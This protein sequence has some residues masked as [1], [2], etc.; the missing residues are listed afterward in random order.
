[1][2]AQ[3][4]DREAK[5]LAAAEEKAKL[6]KYHE[7]MAQEALTAR[8]RSAERAAEQKAPRKWSKMVCEVLGRAGAG[9]L[10]TNNAS[11]LLYSHWRP[12]ILCHRQ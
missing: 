9:D 6:A 10:L 1:V 2:A 3:K 11:R 8:K 5:K 4:A 12:T 7:R